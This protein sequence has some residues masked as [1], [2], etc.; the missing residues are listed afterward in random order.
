MATL[1]IAGGYLLA[2]VL[3]RQRELKERQR[4]LEERERRIAELERSVGLD[5]PGAES[6]F[7]TPLMEEIGRSGRTIP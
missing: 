4:E 5:R 3:R 6:P 7:T 1:L 2:L